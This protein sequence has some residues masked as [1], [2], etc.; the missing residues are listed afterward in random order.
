MSKH[1]FVPDVDIKW[2]CYVCNSNP[3]AALVK[4]CEDQIILVEKKLTPSVVQKSQIHKNPRS[5]NCSGVNED[6]F[7][8]LT[9][10]NAL[11]VLDK[12][13]PATDAVIIV[14]PSMKE[15]LVKT[16]CKQSHTTIVSKVKTVLNE[17]MKTLKEIDQTYF[18][19]GIDRETIK[20]NGSANRSVNGYKTSVKS[21]DSVEDCQASDEDSDH[22]ALVESP[23][24]R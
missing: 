12:L 24:K 11:T 3:L 9:T 18:C 21:T 1:L 13:I 19:N 17:F 14:L 4:R 8:N 15:Q 20:I 5:V 16:K 7:A 23:K 10:A 2:H 22:K 6:L